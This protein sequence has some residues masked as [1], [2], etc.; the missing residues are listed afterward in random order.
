MDPPGTT[1]LAV[2]RN[3][4]RCGALRLK[5]VNAAALTVSNTLAVFVTPSAMVMTFCAPGVADESP[6]S[7]RP[8]RRS[9]CHRRRAAPGSRRC[10]S[11]RRCARGRAGSWWPTAGRVES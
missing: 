8:R 9:R 2:N 11:G 6:A 1:A 10:A 7:P 5:L 4:Q 3:V